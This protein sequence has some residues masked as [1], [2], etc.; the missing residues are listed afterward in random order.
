MVID[1]MMLEKIFTTFH[2]R[3][4]ILQQQYRVKNFT[5]FSELIS[6]LLVEK[7]NNELLMHNHPTRPS[8]PVPLSKTNYGQG[9]WCGRSNGYNNCG[10]RSYCGGHGRRDRVRGQNYFGPHDSR[11][12][13]HQ[14]KQ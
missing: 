12:N 5:N 7:Q 11:I 3:D 8:G 10:G 4:V 2:A 9:K 1:N 13:V 6:C 14:Q